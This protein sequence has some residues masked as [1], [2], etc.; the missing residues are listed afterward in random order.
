[1]TIMWYLQNLINNGN[2][3]VY[4]MVSAMGLV[5]GC[6]IGIITAIQ[7]IVT[8]ERKSGN[9]YRLEFEGYLKQK[10]GAHE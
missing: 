8:R 6:I 10:G 9:K 7:L 5:L 4:G 2:F 1:M 3:A